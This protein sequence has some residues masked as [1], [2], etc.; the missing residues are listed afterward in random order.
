MHRIVGVLVARLPYFFRCEAQNRGQ[1][2]R[3]ASKRNVENR[4][5]GAQVEAG[6]RVAVKRVFSDVEIKC[7]Q[8]D[9]HEIEQRLIDFAE[10]IARVIFAHQRVQFPSRCRI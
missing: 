5:A 1:P 8:V 6:G 7:R 2:A 4:A 9:G 3:Q 10:I